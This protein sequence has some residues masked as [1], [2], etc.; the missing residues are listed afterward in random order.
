[1]RKW[2]SLIAASLLLVSLA[3]CGGTPSSHS[4]DVPAETQSTA[5]D[6]DTEIQSE[7]VEDTVP[8]VFEEILLV[9]NDDCTFKITGIDANNPWGYTWNVYLENKSS[10]KNMMFSL[11]DC[12]VNGIMADPLW[13][14]SVAVGMKSNTE[15][16]WYD[17]SF[18]S[19]G[20]EQVTIVEGTLSVYDDDDWITDYYEGGFRVCPLGEAAVQLAQLE[21]QDSDIVLIDTDD[22]QVIATGFYEDDIWGYTMQLSIVNHTDKDV[23]VSIENCAV[24]GYMADPFWATTVCGGKMAFSDVSWLS[25]DFELNGIEDVETISLTLQ[26]SDYNSLSILVS[27][28]VVIEP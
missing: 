4:A 21:T 10:E 19:H 3:G 2:L 7:P 13:A 5:S 20:V 27:E 16:T 6:P 1:M 9:D 8:Q 23:M 26:I 25:D 22:F 14:E 28:N 11:R 12:S 18:L 17:D 24:N 15:I